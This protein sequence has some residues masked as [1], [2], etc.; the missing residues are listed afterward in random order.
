MDA[1]LEALAAAIETRTL[2]LG[3]LS[4]MYAG[5]TLPFRVNWT[6]GQK[7]ARWALARELTD[8]RKALENGKLTDEETTTLSERAEDNASGW[9]IWWAEVFRMTPDDAERLRDAL[10]PPHWE[11]VT[12]R[13]VAAVFDYEAAE[14]KKAQGGPGSTSE[15]PDESHQNSTSA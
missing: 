8:I 4:E 9:M 7:K 14:T 13:I 2:D 5:V 10:P 3:E 11:W 12:A 1:L 6:R 15:E